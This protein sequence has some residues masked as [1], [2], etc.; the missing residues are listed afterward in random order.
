MGK[1]TENSLKGKDFLYLGPIKFLP[2]ISLREIWKWLSLYMK[3]KNFSLLQFVLF[4]VIKKTLEVPEKNSHLKLMIFAMN[5]MQ[6]FVCSLYAN[7]ILKDKYK[8]NLV[9]WF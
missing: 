9:S 7:S 6:Y 3:K 2:E 1:V 4:Y 5:T 8:Q